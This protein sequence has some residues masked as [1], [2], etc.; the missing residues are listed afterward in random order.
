MFKEKL[1]SFKKLFKNEDQN[2][3]CLVNFNV[4]PITDTNFHQY[5]ISSAVHERCRWTQPCNVLYIQQKKRRLPYFLL[6]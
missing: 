1:E 3:N 6:C 5:I 2:E 4:D